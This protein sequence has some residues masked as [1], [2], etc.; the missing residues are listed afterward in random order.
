[1]SQIRE[2]RDDEN[3]CANEVWYGK[4]HDGGV[5][6]RV[7]RLVGWDRR[8]DPVLGTEEAYDVAYDALYEELPDCKH[9]EGLCRG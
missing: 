1:M 6:E 2:V 5:R 4:G 8:P 7:S 3:F 9:S